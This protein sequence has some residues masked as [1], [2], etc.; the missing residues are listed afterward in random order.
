M[1]Y[2]QKQSARRQREARIRWQMLT[3]IHGSRSNSH[4]GWIT[5]RGVVEAMGYCGQDYTPDDDSHARGLLTDLVLAEYIEV[6]DNREDES[7]PYGLNHLTYKL[8]GKGSGFINRTEPHDALVG[9]GR[10]AK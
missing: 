10:I 5:G 7:Q 1:N 2:H 6:Q 8:T 3:V 4:G 9:D